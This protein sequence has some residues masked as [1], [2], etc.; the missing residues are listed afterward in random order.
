MQLDKQMFDELCCTIINIKGS[1][2]FTAVLET[3]NI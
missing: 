2:V 1:H 3:F